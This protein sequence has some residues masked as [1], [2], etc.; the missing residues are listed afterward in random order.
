MLAWSKIILQFSDIFPYLFSEYHT[1]MGK[2]HVWPTHWTICSSGEMYLMSVFLFSSHNKYTLFVE[3]KKK[4]DKHKIPPSLSINIILQFQ[5]TTCEHTNPLEHLL[6]PFLW[7]KC[8]FLLST[9]SFRMMYISRSWT[10]QAYLPWFNWQILCSFIV[11]GKKQL[12]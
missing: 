3:R 1:F 12:P 2:R 8:V 10:Q 7:S 5:F 11:N 4:T 9:F 6:F